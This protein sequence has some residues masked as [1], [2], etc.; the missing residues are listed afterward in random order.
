[1]EIIPISKKTASVLDTIGIWAFFI[2]IGIF[3]VWVIGTFLAN[4]RVLK[5]RGGVIMIEN[6]KGVFHRAWPDGGLPVVLIIM[7][8]PVFDGKNGLDYLDDLYNSISKGSAYYIPKVKEQGEKF[9]GV[10]VTTT[11]AMTDQRQLDKT[12]P[13]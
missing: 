8:L 3:A 1:M 10:A 6:K 2:V 5:G 7:F 12:L 9:K 4:I 13:L 11:L